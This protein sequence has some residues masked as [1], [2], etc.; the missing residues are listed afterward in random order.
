MVDLTKRAWWAPAWIAVCGLPILWLTATTGFWE[1]W[2]FQRL[3]DAL[4]GETTGWQSLRPSDQV[5][6]WMMPL[7]SK[8][9]AR[10]PF[11][12]GALTMGTV[13]FV[14]LRRN[15]GV[16]AASGAALVALTAPVSLLLG[17]SGMHTIAGMGLGALL[18]VCT[19]ALVDPKLFIPSAKMDA[20]PNAGSTGANPRSVA[21]RW[22]VW[23]LLL[24]LSTLES[25]AL[26]G[27]LVPLA[28]GAVLGV[29]ATAGVASAGVASTASN[30]GARGPGLPALG[31]LV[32]T[33][34]LGTRVALAVVQD[35]AEGSLWLGGIPTGG[36]PPTF[37]KMIRALFHG[38]GPW[39]GVLLVAW[40]SAASPAD[41]S[42]STERRSEPSARQRWGLWAALW[43]VSGAVGQ[44]LFWARYGDGVFML[45]IVPGAILVGL[46]VA[47]VQRQDHALWFEGVVGALLVALV[48]RDYRLYPNATLTGLPTHSLPEGLSTSL[49]PVAAGLFVMIFVVAMAAGKRSP[50]RSERGDS[51]GTAQRFPLTQ[52]FP[53]VALLQHQ[54][55]LGRGTRV[56]VVALGALVGLMFLYWPA[57]W[58][59]SGVQ[60]D[61]VSLLEQLGVSTLVVR[62]AWWMPAA[63]AALVGA[64]LLGPWVWKWMGALRPVR[65]ALLLLGGL[66]CAFVVGFTHLPQVNARFSSQGAYRL[67]S[68][69]SEGKGTLTAY[70]ARADMASHYAGRPVAAV[71]SPEDAARALLTLDS[72][73]ERP[74]SSAWLVTPSDEIAAVD[75]AFR[76]LGQP[77][78]FL[79]VAGPEGMG[80]QLATRTPVEHMPNLNPLLGHVFRELPRTPQVATDISF[81]NRITMLGYD[82]MDLDSSPVDSVGPGE[83]FRVRWYFR[84][85]KPVDGA[86]QLFLHIDGRGQRIHGDHHPVEGLFPANLW[87]VGDVIVDEQELKVPFNY[88]PG[89]YMIHIGFYKGSNRMSVI[90]GAQ[91]GDNRAR[92]GSLLIR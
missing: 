19:L 60:L 53:V 22:A 36:V 50:S 27:A 7:G 9:A 54:W 84:C 68:K 56:W 30:G 72:S 16:L 70:R 76:T 38:F 5:T 25:G 86:Y 63:A 32:A 67:W 64:A 87:L 85:E 21:I 89:S 74:T 1:P 77:D 79:F 43:F 71:T 66:L 44:L 47:H 51:T 13:A 45:P 78:Q 59:L 41:S 81:D 17:S 57:L 31:V 24:L 62:T 82:V 92:A 26:L 29:V 46:W 80:V 2:E 90:R 15:Q 37:D 88:R 73:G 91:D 20:E 35:P 75:R 3:L 4:N 48:V 14:A 55:S 33:L 39:A 12:L 40:M 58:M 42:A 34:I 83:T 11:V 69:L 10:L 52:R 28:P 8:L 6:R 65:G 61:G 49:W 18:A 23:A